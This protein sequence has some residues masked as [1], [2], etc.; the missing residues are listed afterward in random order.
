MHAQSSLKVLRLM[1]RMV[2][3]IVKLARIL[4]RLGHSR[5]ARNI[6]LSQV[7][8]IVRSPSGLEI[9]RLVTKL[10]HV[11]AN[12]SSMMLFVSGEFRAAMSQA[13]YDLASRPDD[14][15][16]RMLVVGCAIEL[17]EF[18][19]AEYHLNVLD[20]GQSPDDLSEQ[21]PFFRFMLAKE[22]G[23]KS[24]ERAVRHLD[25]VYLSMG[26]QPVRMS[27]AEK[28]QAFD[29]LYS[30]EMAAPH[31]HDNYRP[32]CS[33]P[34]VSVIMTAY[35]VEHLVETSVKSILNQ[36][37]R[38]LELI[39]V[40]DCSTDGTLEVLR[41][42]EA[43]DERMQVIVKEKNEGTYVSKNTGLL[44][45]R[46]E[47]VAFQDSDD[48]SHPD[49]LGKS[50]AV[51]ESE[52]EVVALTTNWVRMTTEGNMI[53]Q[54]KNEYSYKALISLVFRRQEVL[55]RLGFFDS[56][57]AEGDGEFERRGRILF[58]KHRVVNCPWTLSFGRV[59][60]G[61][62]TANE[63]FG[64]MRGTG[65]PIREQYR[66]AYRK[67]HDNIGRSHDGYMPFPQRERPFDA[68][69]AILA[70]SK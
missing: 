44:R 65:R 5:T 33:G 35:N 13:I 51:L 66:N 21:L 46:G 53:L 10:R 2:R 39:V 34:L 19:C 3:K 36:N 41:F 20:A 23:P 59:R 64:L 27:L 52:P 38:D 4:I 48:W 15:K 42:M 57:R 70:G 31:C 26:C 47:F 69:S 67:W 28:R 7:K 6:L 58:G 1:I 62:I 30:D 12:S 60:P 61:S 16:A 56:V 29:S 50:I 18:D 49:R 40:D 55:R 25:E 32:L 11:T 63:E 24:L 45:A 68:P 22:A 54:V 37:Y 9:T 43:K 8:T 14:A 17:G